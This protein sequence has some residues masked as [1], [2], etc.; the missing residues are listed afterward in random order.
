MADFLE[1][2]VRQ[3]LVNYFCEIEFELE[4]GIVVIVDR[5]FSGLLFH[6]SIKYKHRN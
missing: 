4:T 2:G 3:S 5:I 6:L 1:S